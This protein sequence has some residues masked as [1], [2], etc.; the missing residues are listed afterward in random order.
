M[1]NFVFNKYWTDTFCLFS[2]LSITECFNLLLCLYSGVLLFIWNVLLFVGCFFFPFEAFIWNEKKATAFI[3]TTAA[4]VVLNYCCV[5][6]NARMLVWATEF[7]DVLNFILVEW[8]IC[9]VVF[10]LGKN[11]PNVVWVQGLDLVF[12]NKSSFTNWIYSSLCPWSLAN[13][14]SSI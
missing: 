8:L 13:I 9:S 1:A 3:A 12:F 7:W 6:I 10:L 5:E 11:T 4:I 14:N 2:Q